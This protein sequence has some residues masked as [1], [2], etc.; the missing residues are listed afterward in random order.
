MVSK[1]SDYDNIPPNYSGYA[2]NTLYMSGG[3]AYTEDIGGVSVTKIFSPTLVSISYTETSVVASSIVDGIYTPG[4]TGD[5]PSIASIIPASGGSKVSTPITI[6][7]TSFTTV[8]SV[9]VD[10]YP[11]TSL[12][13][14]D[15]TTITC[16]VPSSSIWEGPVDVVVINSV[17]SATQTNGFTYTAPAAPTITSITPSE[18]A[19]AGGGPITIDGT[20]FLW[21]TSATIGGLEIGSFTVVNDTTITGTIPA[22]ANL[23]SQ[24]VAVG[25]AILENGFTYVEQPPFITSIDP[26]HGSTLGGEQ[27]T[28]YGSGFLGITEP[29]VAMLNFVELIDTVV[30]ND[31][32]I[33]GISPGGDPG[34]AVVSV[35]NIVTTATLPTGF[36][37]E[38]SAPTI[39]SINP[40]SGLTNGVVDCG[41]YDPAL[42]TIQGSGFLRATSVSIGS[43]TYT[44]GPNHYDPG[45]FTIQDDTTITLL[46]PNPGYGAVGSVDDVIVSN[47]SGTGTL[48]DGYTLITFPEIYG[49]ATGPYAGGTEL[50]YSGIGLSGLTDLRFEYN[51]GVVLCN[52][53]SSTDTSVTF[54]TPAASALGIPEVGGSVEG[55]IG[56]V[57]GCH[58]SSAAFTYEGVPPSIVSISPDSGTT[59][60]IEVTI[61]GG[62]LDSAYEVTVDGMP[63]GFS[64][65]AHNTLTVTMPAHTDG[66]VNVIVRTSVG[67]S[68]AATFTYYLAPPV[69]TSIIPDAG[70]YNTETP[71]TI[72]GTGFTAETG[73]TFDGEAATN[74]VVVDSTTITCNAPVNMT[75]LESVDVVATNVAGIGTLTDGFTYY[76]PCPTVTGIDPS[77]G[78]VAGGTPIT[79]YGT[80]FLWATDASIP[81][82]GGYPL[83]SFTVVDDNTITAVT[84]QAA[85]PEMVGTPLEVTVTNPCGYA[86]LADAFTY[87]PAPSIGGVG[88]SSS[89]EAGGGTIALYGSGFEHATGATIGGNPITSFAIDGGA[90]TGIIPAGTGYD[91]DIVVESPYGNGTLVGAFSYIPV[92]TVTSISPNSGS[93]AGAEMVTIYGTGFRF[94]TSAVVGGFNNDPISSLTIID[95]NTLAGYT[96]PTS[97]YPEGSTEYVYVT[98][99]AGTSTEV[100]SFQRY[101]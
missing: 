92:P 81:T 41:S 71:V 89:V 77:T 9:T 20:G 47:I 58:A 90:I 45:V 57:N 78:G 75:L 1:I 80:N 30:V 34:Q 95:D 96:Q 67:D 88:P 32:T 22:M 59:D 27:I 55:V 37:F 52:I 38:L 73:V 62:G 24:P 49:N 76:S 98:N 12:V 91:L 68:P 35:T 29:T 7:G 56:V 18:G 16:V 40:N 100:V 70:A 28:I 72:T 31:N 51:S 8:S 60:G 3:K 42:A 99:P 36:T 83:T 15:D 10:G 84:S 2:V 21:A 82:F 85:A 74:L 94:A 61:F 33:T 101:Q 44:P 97:S 54:I 26:T 43:T 50:T 4:T 63:V 86:T 53:I 39:S 5:S 46:I 87:I 66:V 14:V 79:I 93:D 69:V 19:V 11:V 23:G 6:T 48:A 13:I 25:V 65:T 17:G 64:V